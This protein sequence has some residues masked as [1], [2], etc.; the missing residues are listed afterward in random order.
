MLVR[1]VP[2]AILRGAGVGGTVGLIA[3]LRV[4]LDVCQSI[5]AAAVPLVQVILWP[6]FAFASQRDERDEQT[7]I[8][9]TVQGGGKRRLERAAA[10]IW[11]NAW[12]AAFEL[13]IFVAMND[14]DFRLWLGPCSVSLAQR[15]RPA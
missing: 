5:A 12:P 13:A 1:L 3:D 10:L 7:R 9:S 6:E 11:R 14:A 8:S 15:V 4:L 2:V